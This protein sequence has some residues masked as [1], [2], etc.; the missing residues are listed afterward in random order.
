MQLNK[1]QPAI[2]F[3]VGGVLIDWSPKYLFS[4]MFAGEP[5]RLAFFLTKVCPQEWN[6]KQDLGRPFMESVE[7]S[8]LIFPEYEPY[9]R[10]YYERWEE[11]V[12]G[13]IP[14]T[15]E[16][17]ARLREADYCLGGLSNWSGETFPLVRKRYGFLNWFD[18]MIVSGDVGLIKPNPAIYELTLERLGRDAQQCLF[19]DDNAVNTE[20]ADALGFDTILFTSPEQLGNDLRKRDIHF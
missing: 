5:E 15:V 13:D 10:A 14:G 7:E 3:D 2:I 4:K 9:I 17:L 8:V 16:I 12:K 19:I 18:P 20:A 11:T 1:K 6:L